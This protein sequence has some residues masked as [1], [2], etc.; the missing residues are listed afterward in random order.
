MAKDKKAKKA[1]KAA[2]PEI[3]DVSASILKGFKPINDSA[4]VQVFNA[5]DGATLSQ[6]IKAAEKDGR[7]NVVVQGGWGAGAGQFTAKVAEKDGAL[8]SFIVFKDRPGYLFN[9]FVEK[10]KN[11]EGKK[12][13][14]LHQAG[15]PDQALAESLTKGETLSIVASGTTRIYGNIQG[16]V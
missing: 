1:K 5:K 13:P 4:K 7:R 12:F 15:T 11:S 9:V 8:F 3:A 16:R 6:M 10:V 2:S 14:G